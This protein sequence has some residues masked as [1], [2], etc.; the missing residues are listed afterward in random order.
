LFTDTVDNAKEMDLEPLTFSPAESSRFS[1]SSLFADS[2]GNREQKA[3]GFRSR[4]LYL[5]VDEYRIK[6]Q[7]ENT[8]YWK[9]FH[10][11]PRS[12]QE[13]N[14][15]TREGRVLEFHY[16]AEESLPL[17]VDFFVQDRETWENITERTE[18]V[19]EDARGRRMAWG[20]ETARR[21]E[22]G[23][24]YRFHFDA[25]GYEPKTFSLMIRPEQSKLH[26]NP[27]LVP[28]EES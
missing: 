20:P 12:A 10:L 24:V 19:V 25:P 2:A 23:Q 8:L 15:N 5:P 9:S 28:Q 22:T 1:L 11:E 21:L 13:Q 14:I 3:L 7:V 4:R 18:I 27:R 26:L 16:G 17:R 6:L